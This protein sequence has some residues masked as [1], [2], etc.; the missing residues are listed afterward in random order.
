MQC[1][2]ELASH[3]YQVIV[4]L[5]VTTSCLVL[6]YINQSTHSLL[7]QLLRIAESSSAPKTICKLQ[8][9]AMYESDWYQTFRLSIPASAQDAKAALFAPSQFNPRLFQLSQARDKTHRKRDRKQNSAVTKITK[10]G[11]CLPQVEEKTHRI[12]SEKQSCLRPHRKM[13]KD[14]FHWVPHVSTFA[15]KMSPSWQ[16]L[17]TVQ[18]SLV[19]YARCAIQNSE[20]L[21]NSDILQSSVGLF[22]VFCWRI[23]RS[24]ETWDSFNLGGRLRRVLQLWK[25]QGQVAKT[26]PSAKVQVLHGASIAKFEVAWIRTMLQTQVQPLTS[27]S[28]KQWHK[29]T[30]GSTPGSI[31]SHC[32]DL[33]GKPQ[34]LKA[35]VKATTSRSSWWP[36]QK[37]QTSHHG[38]QSEVI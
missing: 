38:W 11:H 19:L 5:V 36:H 27:N 32:E 18:V 21:G 6:L 25:Q 14:D 30:A 7:S 22:A 24:L 37:C 10:C 28:P 4:W 3:H 17:D 20:I 15:I 2:Q 34:T 1:S 26:S 29:S 13:S 35:V 8:V 16:L 9:C 12:E 23:I 33:W 31:H